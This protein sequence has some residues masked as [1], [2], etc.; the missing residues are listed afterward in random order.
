MNSSSSILVL[1]TPR[2]GYYSMAHTLLT[3]HGL[4]ERVMS[5]QIYL[6]RDIPLLG[7]FGVIFTTQPADL[8]RSTCRTTHRQTGAVGIETRRLPVHRPLRDPER[9]GQWRR[10]GGTNHLSEILT[11]AGVKTEGNE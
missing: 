10:A 11:G 1:E 4:R 6:N 7:E 2:A 8:F 3:D 9:S 5:L